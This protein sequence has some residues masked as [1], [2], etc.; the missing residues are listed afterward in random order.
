MTASVDGAARLLAIEEIKAVFAGRLHCLD[1]KDWDR[2]GDF[3]TE[4]VVSAT[5][6]DLPGG[7]APGSTSREVV[8]RENL[9]AAIRRALGGSRMVTTVHHGHNPVI[10]LTSDTTARGT[11]AMEDRL[12]WSEGG[13]EEWLHGF[14]HYHEEY[15]REDGR[16]LISRRQLTRVRVDTTPGFFA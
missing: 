5:W 14:G 16:W 8:G 7:A 9:T 13:R 11:W 12:W 10:E 1:A 3:H 2:Y 6:S 15:R 4:D